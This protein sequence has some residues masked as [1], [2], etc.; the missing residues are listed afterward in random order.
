MTTT[1]TMMMIIVCQGHEISPAPHCRVLPPGEFTGVIAELSDVDTERFTT[2]D[3][4][5]YMQCCWVTNRQQSLLQ[6]Y[7]RRQTY[8]AGCTSVARCNKQTNR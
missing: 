4:T 6:S 2:V 5:V 7:R 8:L 3:V 1:T